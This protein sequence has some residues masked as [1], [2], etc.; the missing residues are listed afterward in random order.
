V[1][2][3]VFNNNAYG[4]VR[5]DQMNVFDG[6]LLGA[7]LTNP[8]FV[9]LAKSFGMPAEKAET[10]EALEKAIEKALANGGPALIEVPVPRGSET[11]PWQ[12]LHPAP[13]S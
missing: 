9:A 4:N 7:D 5:R 3:V 10:P 6:R 11:S 8:D 13:H 2:A 12:F 1:I